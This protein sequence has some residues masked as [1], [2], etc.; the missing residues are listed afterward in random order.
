LLDYLLLLLNFEA[1]K[2]RVSTTD[3]F[4][5]VSRGLRLHSQG[6]GI[7][8]RHCDFGQLDWRLLSDESYDAEPRSLEPTVARLVLRPRHLV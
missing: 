4:L 6:S 1:G 2:Y 7:V 5:C 3:F 8:G